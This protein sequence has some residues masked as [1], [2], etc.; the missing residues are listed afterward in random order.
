VAVAALAW[1]LVL[2][3]ARLEGQS[4]T[5]AW[6]SYGLGV[7][8]F[9]F[10]PLS[11]H[12]RPLDFPALARYQLMYGGGGLVQSG[13]VSIAGY[14]I[15][16]TQT[17]SNSS[18]F[19]KLGYKLAMVE[20]GWLPLSTAHLKLGPALGL[21]MAGFE[22]ALWPRDSAW[23]DF[24]SLFVRGAQAWTASNRSFGLLP[25]LNVIIPI[26]TVGLALKAGYVWSP[27]DR[28]WSLSQG[29]PV[30]NVPALRSSGFFGCVQVILGGTEN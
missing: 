6:G 29:I 26:K 30:N 27:W 19:L 12:L 8:L 28:H 23:A 18:A 10:A 5:G 4:Q 15:G 9:N 24:D 14:G 7:G 25:V 17:I 3:A 22:L 21:G 13:R 1:L 16:G 20:I 2:S 11:D